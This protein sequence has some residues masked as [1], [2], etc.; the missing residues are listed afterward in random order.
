MGQTVE[1]VFG[2]DQGL[3]RRAIVAKEAPTPQQDPDWSAE[4]ARG[5]ATCVSYTVQFEGDRPAR[6]LFVCDLPDGRRALAAS[7]DL[8][9]ARLVYCCLLSF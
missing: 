9:E 2:A 3:F 8:A 1:T 6:T 5:D 7:L 4:D